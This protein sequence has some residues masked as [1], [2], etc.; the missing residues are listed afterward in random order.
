MDLIVENEHSAL[1]GDT[2]FR[3]AVGKNGIIAAFAKREGDNKTPAGRWPMREVIYRA[4][5]LPKPE[6]SLPV[7]AMEPNDG[8]SET[9]EDPKYN[10]LI[11]HPHKFSAERMWRDDHLYDV[12]VVLGHND[13][14]VVPKMGSAIFFHVARPDYSPSA[15][16]VTLALEDVLMV[17]R[18]AN[19]QSYVD[20]RLP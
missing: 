19:A 17:L 13:R 18:E 8:W 4:D 2:R 14:P 1:W 11:H 6:T 9:P 16:C 7:R 10:Q 5:R 3:C 20:V 12:V 15:G